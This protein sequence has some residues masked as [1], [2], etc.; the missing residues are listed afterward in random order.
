MTRIE[1]SALVMHS[2]QQMYDVVNNVQF[3]PEF[4][5][6]CAASYIKQ[7]SPTQMVASLSLAKAGLKYDFTTRNTLDAPNSIDLVLEEG[8]FKHLQGQWHFTAL[9]DE[10]CKV[11]LEL[12]FSFPGKLTSMAMS[13]VF[14]QVAATMVDA[15]V[16]RADQVYSN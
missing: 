9:S 14:S 6:W 13:K 8:P 1:R 7:Q 15:F 2:A 11:S 12:D 10:A 4:L 3:Y 16:N 5:P